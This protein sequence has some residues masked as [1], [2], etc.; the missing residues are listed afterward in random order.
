VVFDTNVFAYALLGPATF[1]VPAAAALQRYAGRIWAP[2]TVS[3]VQ[4]WVRPPLSPKVEHGFSVDS[5]WFTGR[6][7]SFGL[8]VEIM[9]RHRPPLERVGAARAD[10]LADLEAFDLEA[11][12][13]HHPC[14]AGRTGVRFFRKM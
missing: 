2:E 4:V 13:A 10:R 5:R 8:K 14:T 12:S 3:P 6:A 7:T 9:A 1:G 11:G